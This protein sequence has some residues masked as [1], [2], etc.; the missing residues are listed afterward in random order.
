MCPAPMTRGAALPAADD[1]STESAQ[2]P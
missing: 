1:N 2:M